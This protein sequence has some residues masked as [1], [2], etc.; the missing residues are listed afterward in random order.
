[1][2]VN[3]GL[4]DEKAGMSNEDHVEAYKQELKRGDIAWGPEGRMVAYAGTAA[5]LVREIKPAGEIVDE[6]IA[7]CQKVL[8]SVT[9]RL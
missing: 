5:G 8:R 9:A 6:V 1:M 3:Q 7:D 4:A 2:I